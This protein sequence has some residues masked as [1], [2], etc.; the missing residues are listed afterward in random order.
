MVVYE[1]KCRVTGKSYIGKTQDYLKKRTQQHA[2]DV[3]KV[4]ESGRAK[5]G[6]DELRGSGGYKG[7]DAYGGIP[8]LAGSLVLTRILARK[9]QIFLAHKKKQLPPP[10]THIY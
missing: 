6:H 3:W 4:F 2:T 1:L 10:T 7:A 5:Y 9:F 8:I